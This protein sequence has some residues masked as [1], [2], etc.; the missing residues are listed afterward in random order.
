MA[1]TFSGDV[2][3]FV[4]NF[5]NGS[6]RTVR[7]TAGNLFGDI[8][9][10]TPVDTGRARANWFATGISQSGKT[11]DRVDK[12]GDSA[13]ASAQKVTATLKDWSTFKL[14]NNLSYIGV[15][16]FGLYGDGPLTTGGFSKQAPA[17]M[18]RI[19]VLRFNRLIQENARLYLPK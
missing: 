16:E 10:A 18:L 3:S 19:N 5:M 8:I 9:K 2:D 11:T 14:T 4:V 17:G 15:L 6:E 12:S 13:A 1:R 7:V